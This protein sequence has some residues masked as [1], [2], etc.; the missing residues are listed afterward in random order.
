M[1]QT[2]QQRPPGQPA[3]VLKAF[4]EATA[5][6]SSREV[7]ALTGIA[8]T[9]IAKFRR[10]WPQVQPHPRV[11]RAIFHYLQGEKPVNDPRTLQKHIEALDRRLQTVERHLRKEGSNGE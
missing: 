9:T 1:T 11:L 2:Q 6:Y 4:L 3:D 5:H 10:D 7:E 8:F